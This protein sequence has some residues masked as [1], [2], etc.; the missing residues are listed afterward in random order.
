MPRLG[1]VNVQG[2]LLLAEDGLALALLRF[3]PEGTIDEHAAG[4]DI[5]VVCLE[6]EGFISIEHRVYSFG[7]GETLRWPAGLVHRLW[8]GDSSMLALMVE[9]VLGT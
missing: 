5:D 2:R 8:T 1:C 3:D 4:H 7:S 9:R 6:G